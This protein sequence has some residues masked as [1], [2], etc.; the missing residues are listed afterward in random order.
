MDKMMY[1]AM[2]GAKNLA[3]AQATN[4]NN[5]ANAGTTGFKAD[6]D[7]FKSLPVQGPGHAS[8]VYS[9]DERAGTDFEQGTIISTGRALDVAIN[10]KGWIAVQGADGNEAYSRRG[11]LRLDA[12]GLLTDGAGNLVLGNG[13]PI[14]L[15]PHESLVIGRDGSISIVPLGQDAT[16]LAITDRIRLVNMDESKL[17]KNSEGLFQLQE[18]EAAIVDGNIQ[19]IAGSLE[20]SN[21]SSVD[22]MV[23]MIEY[24]RAFETQVKLMKIVEKVDEQADRLVRLN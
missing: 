24:S 7:A 6:L 13:G 20:T 11:D 21:V 8:R 14:A 12:N 23:R 9:Q 10:G 15:P 2:A 3:I 17:H 5:L 19:V 16:T 22:A 4:A 18:G 1:L